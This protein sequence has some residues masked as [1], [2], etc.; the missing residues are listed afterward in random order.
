MTAYASDL[1]PHALEASLGLL[2]WQPAL[3]A[4]YLAKHEFTDL[5]SP[6]QW[7][8][9]RSFGKR[10]KPSHVLIPG[11]SHASCGYC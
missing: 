11:Q 5:D 3:N 1:E 6:A 4:A 8:L 2:Q 9:L 10:R 7:W